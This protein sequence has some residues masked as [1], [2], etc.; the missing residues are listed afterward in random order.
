MKQATP[1]RENLPK[2]SPGSGFVEVSAEAGNGLAKVTM[3]RKHDVKRVSTG[4]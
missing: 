3:T 2:K 4:P 1:C